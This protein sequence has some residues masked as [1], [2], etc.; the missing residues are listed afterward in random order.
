MEEMPHLICFTKLGLSKST[1][2][3]ID[4]KVQDRGQRKAKTLDYPKIFMIIT[5]LMFMV[6]P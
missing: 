4:Y 6:L 3:F 2:V 5:V 1:V